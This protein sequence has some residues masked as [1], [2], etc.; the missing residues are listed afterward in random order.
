MQVED[1]KD[2]IFIYDLDAE[3]A[4]SDPEEDRL[5]FIPDIEKHLTKIPKHVLTGQDEDTKKENQLV[6]YQVPTALSVPEDE[7]SVRK[8]IIETRTRAQQRQEKLHQEL[9]SD[10]V[11]SRHEAVQP[12]SGP[13]Q[14]MSEIV[15]DEDDMDAMDIE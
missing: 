10:G 14:T 11:D 13:S 5:V 15:M 1:T 4:E 3:L 2:K 6:L 12:S 8:A 7:D 9:T